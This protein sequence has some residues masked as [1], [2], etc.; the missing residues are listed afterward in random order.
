MDVC[1]TQLLSGH[2]LARG[3]LHEG[4][5]AEEDRAGALD[6]HGLVAHRRHVRAAGGARSHDHRDLRDSLGRHASLVEEDAAE[7]VAVGEDLV[8]EREKGAA[9][10]DEVDAGQAVLF[11]DLLGTQVLLD[12]ERVI[13]SA[14]DGGVVRDD[15][16]LPTLDGPDAADDSGAGSIAVVEVPRG[17]RVQ[18]EER[19]TRVEQAVDPL[20]G[21]K[22]PPSPVALDGLGSA[23][24]CDLLAAS[25]KLGDQRLHPGPV[26]LELWC[27]PVDARIEDRH[28]REAYG[29][30]RPGSRLN[31]K[32][33]VPGALGV[34]FRGRC[35]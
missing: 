3:R 24:L 12:G 6:D 14:L 17:E 9:R 21:C 33:P 30:R 25:A 35:C 2:F 34:S 20:P 16:A 32:D 15:H 8:L 31:A 26:R 11:R 10:I 7:V 29:T 22:L 27:C 18:L 19:R 1:T 28:G 23:T 4:R 13:G 5:A